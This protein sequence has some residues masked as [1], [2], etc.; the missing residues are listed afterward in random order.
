MKRVLYILVL[1]VVIVTVIISIN[2]FKKESNFSVLTINGSEIGVVDLNENTRANMQFYQSNKKIDFDAKDGDKMEKLV[3]KQVLQAMAEDA[4]VEKLVS[5]AGINISAQEIQEELDR[6][7]ESVGNRENLENN[8][9]NVF[10][11]TIDDFKN[12]VVK[13]QIAEQELRNFVSNDPSLNENAYNKMKEILERVRNGE[14]FGELAKE[15]SDCPS[16]ARGGDLGEFAKAE[17]DFQNQYPHMVAPFEEATF[18]L[19]LGEISDIVKT[20]FGYHI[21]KLMGKTID[22]SGVPVAEASHILLKTTDYDSWFLKKK[23]EADVK[24]YDNDF[25]W[26][27]E[28]GTIEFTNEEMR[29]FE[30]EK[31]H[32]L[33]S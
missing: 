8:L 33:E 1:I 21:I 18:A 6:V 10:G 25:V 14:D 12:N 30:T 5:D 23:Q 2:W 29:K 4:L 7:I 28:M 32:E 26:N 3:K 17:D 13:S 16:G 11:W 20:Q 27:N 15:F 31:Q 22:D 19:E 24:V 9:S